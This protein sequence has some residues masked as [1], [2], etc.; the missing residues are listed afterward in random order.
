MNFLRLLRVEW[1]KTMKM[2][3]TYIA[4]LACGLLVLLVQ[5]GVYYNHD[6]NPFYKFL[7]QNDLDVSLLVNGYVSTRLTLEIGFVLLMAPMIIQVFARQVA[8]EDLRGTLRMVLSRPVSRVS[9]VTAKFLVG[10]GYCI[11]LMGFCLALSFGTG[12]AFW[13]AKNS[14]T[15]GNFDEIDGDQYADQAR[16]MAMDKMREDSKLPPEQRR[17][18]RALEREIR[19]EFIH[20]ALLEKVIDPVG[21]TKRLAL[22]WAMTSWALI[23]IGSIALFFSVINKHPIAAMALTVGLYFLVLIMQELSNADNVLPIFK[24]LRPYLFTT[25]M[26]FWRECL[27]YDI[28]WEVLWSKARLLGGYTLGFFAISQ[29]LFWRKDIAS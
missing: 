8:G 3:S 23:T 11:L 18:R 12:M 29:F 21:Q 5:L 20:K 26:D 19:R 10:S 13:G 27:S 1:I 2:M 17:D 15:V 24:A 6:D 4:F 7:S 25:A 9:L 28:R 16:Q 22:A 14:I